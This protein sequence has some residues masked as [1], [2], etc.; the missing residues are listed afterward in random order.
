MLEWNNQ[1]RRKD[2]YSH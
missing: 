2:C 1:E